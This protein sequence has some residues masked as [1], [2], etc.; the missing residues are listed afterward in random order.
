MEVLFS[1][2]VLQEASCWLFHDV[3]YGN[4]CRY[5]GFQTLKPVLQQE[6]T[7]TD[8]MLVLAGPQA[9]SLHEDLYDR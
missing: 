6:L 2:V 5:A 8:S 7:Y 9:S 1:T 4:C 3:D